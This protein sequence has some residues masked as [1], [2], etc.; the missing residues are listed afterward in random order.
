M[1]GYCDAIR[2][3]E[4]ESFLVPDD[5]HATTRLFNVLTDIQFHTH[6]HPGW[7][8]PLAEVIA[9]GEKAIPSIQHQV[10]ALVAKPIVEVD[11]VHV[12]PESIL[13]DQRNLYKQQQIPKLLYFT[14]AL[15]YIKSP[16]IAPPLLTVLEKNI[17]MW[18]WPELLDNKVAFLDP[19]ERVYIGIARALFWVKAEETLSRLKDILQ[20]AMSRQNSML[21]S[22]PYAIRA[23]GFLGTE[24]EITIV[25][26]FLEFSSPGFD[27]SES[28]VRLEAKHALYALQ[29]PEEQEERANSPSDAWRA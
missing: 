27:V 6:P 14:I 18:I 13:Q 11:A 9:L 10:Y 21:N 1:E 15:C 26:Q 4:T 24:A 7:P 5:K 25:K 16:I 2:A 28:R 29:H 20:Q 3:L 17:Q 22:L 8:K 19:F 12:Q 23:I